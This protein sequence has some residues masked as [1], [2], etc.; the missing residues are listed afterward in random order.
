VACKDC[1]LFNGSGFYL[2]YGLIVLIA[3]VTKFRARS[4][5]S[6]AGFTAD[7]QKF[8]PFTGELAEVF[9]ARASISAYLFQAILT[10][11]SFSFFSA[12]VR[13][14]V[15]FIRIAFMMG[16]NPSFLV[17]FKRYFLLYYVAISLPAAF[18]APVA[19]A[20]RK[21]D[22]HL[23]AA[24][25]LLIV[26]NAIGDVISVRLTLRNF[27]KLKF[28][29]TIHLDNSA[30]EFQQSIRNELTYY[31]AVLKGSA[32]PLVVLIVILAISSVLYGV[33][34]GHLDFAFSKSFLVGV[35]DRILRFPELAF[36]PYWF[37]DQP[38]PFGTA[39]I[40]GLFLFG[41]ISFIPVI[42]L[43]GVA[44][45]WIILLPLRMAINLPVGRVQKVVVSETAVIILCA[46]I[47]YALH[48]NVLSLY[49]FLIHT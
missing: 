46:M 35:W 12:V 7:Q 11:V 30:A 26:I 20:Q 13:R 31:L 10:L 29:E 27:E 38:G 8:L 2:A 40:P 49:G 48:I 16:D 43:F 5:P 24:V 9:A 36:Q 39:G 19:Y 47:T 28:D 44:V 41:I 1:A 33:Q 25:V 4:Q 42:I 17:S 23:L 3:S 21:P 37:R 45:V 22:F 32:Y 18:M 6:S 34:V 14:T 15:G